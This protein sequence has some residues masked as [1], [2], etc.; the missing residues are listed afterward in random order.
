QAAAAI[1]DDLARPNSGAPETPLQAAERLAVQACLDAMSARC[2]LAAERARAALSF[3]A[4]PGFHAMMASLALIMA[5]GALG[6]VDELSGVAEQALGR[7]T[8]SFQA[9]HMRFWFGAVYGRACRLTGRIDEFVTTAEELA[10]SARDLP[11]LAYA[12]LALLL[13]NAD[14]VRGAVADAARLLHEALAGVERHAVTTGLRAASYFALAEAHAKL[15]QPTEANDA[16]AGARS[17]VPPDFLF[18]HTALSLASGWAMAASGRLSEAVTSAQQAAQLVRERGQPTHELACIQAAA[19]WGDASQAGR[20]RELGEAL[21]LPLANAVALHAESLLAGDGEGLLAA[22]A[23]YRRIGDR[24]A[25]ADAAAQASVAFD[26]SQQHRRGLYAAALAKELAEQCGGL[27]TPAL[28]T[29]AGLKLSGRQRDVV[30]LVV[31]GLSNRQIAEKLV[32]SVRTVEGHVY[33]ACQRVGAQSRE[34][35][36]SIVR[37]GR[38]DGATG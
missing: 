22:S 8:T 4:L 3:E 29:P 6:E 27:C 18:M 36:A 24:A 20:A 14:L 9:S 21:S 32:M 12:N 11:G 23:A 34:E 16:V 35:L 38:G 1:L 31:V 2:G 37:S 15:G 7:A 5:M 30:E 33:R 26:E 10:D 25:A 13:G 28:R 19:Q 17:C